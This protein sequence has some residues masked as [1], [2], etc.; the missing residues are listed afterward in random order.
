ME[1]PLPQPKR[2]SRFRTIQ[3]VLDELC[4]VYGFTSVVLVGA[5]GL[6]LAAT[7][8]EDQY[9]PEILAALAA[10]LR[11]SAR[12]VQRQMRWSSLDE[13]NTVSGDGQRLIARLISFEDEELVLAILM[14]HWMSYRKA[15]TQALEVIRW[16]W[17]H[18]GPE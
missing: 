12:T 11:S 18:R 6:P 4:E 16:A 1:D 8:L 9:D 5:E 7:D 13:V 17:Q 15:T 3:R 10:H 14:P 2:W